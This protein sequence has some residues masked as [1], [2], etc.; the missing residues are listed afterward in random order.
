MNSALSR[1]RARR[2][3]G[4]SFSFPFRLFPS[5]LLSRFLT[6]VFL[7]FSFKRSVL[8]YLL[9]HVT[10]WSSPSAR[11][12]LLRAARPIRAANRLQT[13]YPLIAEVIA[14]APTFGPESK[15]ILDLLFDSFDKSSLS[16]IAESPEIWDAFKK[17]LTVDAATP[18]GR[19]VRQA[20]LDQLQ[21]VFFQVLPEN[22]K[23]D[24]V[25]LLVRSITDESSVRVSTFR[26]VFPLPD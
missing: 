4:A 10:A 1:E 20:A 3:L 23:V 18:S 9:S 2:S 24:L 19:M 16:V 25:E 15:S 5:P 7:F 14:V 13:L 22:E 26:L 8:S 17:S 21:S 12:T 6:C 11:I